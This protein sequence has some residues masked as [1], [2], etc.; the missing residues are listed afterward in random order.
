MFKIVKFMNIQEK[1]D[2]QEFLKKIGITGAALMAV[3]CVGGL[4][5][6]ASN[7]VTP[8]MSAN[9]TLD[10]NSTITSVNSFTTQNGVVVVRIAAGNTESA[11]VAVSQTCPHEGQKQV[12]YQGSTSKGFRCSA[13]GA[14]FNILGNA[15]SGVTS[16]SL[17]IFKVTV[18]GTTL[19][20]S[21]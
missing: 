2:R 16:G 4:A 6:C 13:H 15:T 21:N 11:F 12:S 14:T 3:Y 17:Q 10:L 5:G 9:F 7:S 19:S 8:S 20:V 1:I 18:S